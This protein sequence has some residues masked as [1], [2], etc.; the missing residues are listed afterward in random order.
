M[1]IKALASPSA[2]KP[3]ARLEF[4]SG[5]L[6]PEQ[7]DIDVEYCGICHSDLSMLNND[8][9]MTQYPFVPG[10]EIVGKIRSVGDRVKHLSAGQTVGLGWFSQSCMTCEQCVSGNHNLCAAGEGT[11]VGRHGGFASS[12]R[13]HSAWAIPIP[14]NVDPV[15]AGPLFCGG[16]TVFNP[17]IQNNICPTNHV[18]VVGIGG[19][20]HM[21]L[22]FLRSWG[23]E[24]TAFST[25]PDKEA[26][27]RKLGAHNFLNS[28][29]PSIFEQYA[30]SLDMILVTVNVDLNWDAYVSL[31]KP[32][33]KLHVVGAANQLV[34]TIFPLLLG[35]KSVGASPVGSPGTTSQMLKFA[36]RHGIQPVIEKFPMSRANEAL[37]H[38][39]EGKARYRIVLENDL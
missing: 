23:C 19:L 33:G 4:D 27:A 12:V 38:L 28:K 39:A 9:Q 6:A 18:G 17:I 26:A 29:D 34:A 7:V 3:L 31:L 10:H 37:E 8:W 22:R 21:A 14:E 24:V 16:L 20:G 1:K 35:Q 15:S 13:C 5:D 2:G 36:G 25:S 11:I 30:G 32:K